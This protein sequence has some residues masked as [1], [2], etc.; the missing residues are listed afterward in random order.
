V[1]A[2]PGRAAGDG[3]GVGDTELVM[4]GALYVLVGD[5]AKDRGLMTRIVAGEQHAPTCMR[6]L[7]VE[8]GD[9]LR[10]GQ[11]CSERCLTA[12]MVV[13]W[14]RTWI[15]EHRAPRRV[16]RVEEVAG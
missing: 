7:W 4:L 6:G 10:G 8:M 3:A 16:A 5:G 11:P 14:L 1:T 15:W 12:Q 2:R 13:G 9:S